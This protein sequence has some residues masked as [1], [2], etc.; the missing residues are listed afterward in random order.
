MTMKVFL[1]VF[2]TLIMVSCKSLQISSDLDDKAAFRLYQQTLKAKNDLSIL[3]NADSS[4]AVCVKQAVA[5][6]PAP[7]SFVVVNIKGR[8]KILVSQNSYLGVFWIDLHTLGFEKRMGIS[9][10]SKDPSKPVKKDRYEYYNVEK[11]EYTQYTNSNQST[12]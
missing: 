8:S 2:L 7:V 11:K 5:E 4:Y 6:E 9:I 1:P 12:N 3:Y 10:E